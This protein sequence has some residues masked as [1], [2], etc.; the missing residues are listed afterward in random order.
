M[1]L[2][3]RKVLEVFTIKDT[4]TLNLE[5]HT[6]LCHAR[7]EQEKGVLVQVCGL[8]MKSPCTSQDSQSGFN[9]EY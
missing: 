4:F 7:N 8:F 5:K 3:R 9:N 2:A 1:R 6:R